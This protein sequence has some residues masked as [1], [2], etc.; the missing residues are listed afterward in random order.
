M[1]RKRKYK[2]SYVISIR[3][4]DQ[5]L[6]DLNHI[7]Q[8]MKI[9]RVSDLMRQAIGLVKENPAE[10]YRQTISTE[11]FPAMQSFVQA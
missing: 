6:E 5:E 9:T 11:Q 7:M 8:C 10:G 1:G 4:S 2:K 3:I